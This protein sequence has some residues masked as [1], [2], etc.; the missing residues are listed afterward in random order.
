ME[1]VLKYLK[2]MNIFLKITEFLQQ[3]PIYISSV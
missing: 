1:S 2:Y 3:N